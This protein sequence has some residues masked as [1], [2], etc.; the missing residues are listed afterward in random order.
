MYGCYQSIDLC[1]VRAAQLASDGS[2]QGA[3]T[4]GGAYNLRPISLSRSPTVSTGETFEQRDGC[5]NICFSR[6]DADVTTGE[7]LTLDL[8]QLEGN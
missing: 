3:V 4:N 1:A 5:G 7:D 8:C 6:E 2:K